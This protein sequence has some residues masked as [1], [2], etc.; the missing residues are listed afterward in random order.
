MIKMRFEV[1]FQPKDNAWYVYDEEEYY[2][3][4]P[5]LNDVPILIRKHIKNFR[6]TLIYYEEE[7]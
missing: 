3:F 7:I 4:S 2:Y 6:D 5:K 1:I